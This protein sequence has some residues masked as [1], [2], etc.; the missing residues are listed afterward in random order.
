VV[1]DGTTTV[2]DNDVKKLESVM[3]ARPGDPNWNPA[4]DLDRNNSIDQKDWMILMQ[5]YGK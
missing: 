4:C 1:N 3:G 2:N 5:H